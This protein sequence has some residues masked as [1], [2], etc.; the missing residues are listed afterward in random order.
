MLNHRFIS[1]FG[2]FIVPL[3]AANLHYTVYKKTT[4][5][6]PTLLII[7]GIH[8]NEPGGY[9]APSIFKNNYEITEGNVWI[10]PNLNFDSIVLNRRGVY[11]DMNR[12]FAKIS[13]KDK[14]YE[15]VSDIKNLMLEKDVDLILNLHDGHGFYREQNI[16]NIFNT[17]AWGQACIIDQQEIEGAKFGKLADIAKR[18][19]KETNIA[20]AEDVH[21]FN[22]KNTQTKEKD[23]S[24]QQS[25]TYFAIQNNKAAFAVETSKNI[26]ELDLK[27][28]YQLKSIEEFMNIMGIKYTRN[29]ELTQTSIS[30]LLSNY[31]DI[32]FSKGQIIL[33]LDNLKPIINNF[34]TNKQKLEYSSSNPLI[35]LIK[36]KNNFKVMNGNIEVTKIV[37]QMFDFDNSLTDIKMIVDGQ[38]VSAS[39]GGVIDVKESFR[40]LEQEGYRANIIGFSPQNSDL[41]TNIDIHEED[42]MKRFSVDKNE[43]IFR[44]EFYKN[45]KFSGMLFVRFV[46]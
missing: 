13:D 37:P 27:V 18:V 3:M 45:K 32:S 17:S 30:K 23:E 19:S 39:I 16:D 22:V 43:E 46:S 14:D 20:L 26:I 42:I 12:K 7:G 28:Y 35:A 41:E 34:P 11:G 6:G 36:D 5:S 24:M 15:I 31:G 38:L 21:E 4:L 2:L 44:I 1:L 8:G 29:F 10:V 25:L 9:F 33:P 40:I